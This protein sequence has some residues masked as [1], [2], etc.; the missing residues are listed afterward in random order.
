MKL[1]T[2]KSSVQEH[3]DT[4]TSDVL[5]QFQSFMKNFEDQ[6]SII[7]SDTLN[8]FNNHKNNNNMADGINDVPL[9]KMHPKFNVDPSFAAHLLRRS[10]NNIPAHLQPPAFNNSDNNNSNDNNKKHDYHHNNNYMP[11]NHAQSDKHA[12]FRST[13]P[14]T[15]YDGPKFIP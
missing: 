5:H 4:V 1:Q 8:T 10:P 14:T 11:N 13:T 6:A 3:I 15:E 9:H 7:I 12:S 2:F